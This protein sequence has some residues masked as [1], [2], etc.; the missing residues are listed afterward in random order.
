[1]A[2]RGTSRMV[3]RR[4]STIPA[5]NTTQACT[6]KCAI[7]IVTVVLGAIALLAT[8][9]ALCHYIRRRRTALSTNDSRISAYPP[10]TNE[11]LHRDASIPLQEEVVKGMESICVKSVAASDTSSETYCYHE[12]PSETRSRCEDPKLHHVASKASI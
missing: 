7:I 9:L 4:Q 6:F 5:M 1:M 3:W 8:S 10:R 12:D 11:I 2:P